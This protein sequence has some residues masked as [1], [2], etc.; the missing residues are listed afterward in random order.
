MKTSD[1][2]LL[3]TQVAIREGV[4]DH[5]MRAHGGRGGHPAVTVVTLG[6]PWTRASSWYSRRPRH[7]FASTRRA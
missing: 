3:E 7:R 2:K 6:V 4:T 5:V 1:G